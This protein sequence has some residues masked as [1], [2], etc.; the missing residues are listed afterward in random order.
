MTLTRSIRFTLFAL[1]TCLWTTTLWAKGSGNA[2]IKVTMEPEFPLELSLQEVT[3]GVAEFFVVV[4]NQGTLRDFILVKTSH[5][6]FGEAVEEV[7]PKWDFKPVS[8]EGERINAMHRVTVNFRNYGVFVVGLDSVTTIKDSRVRTLAR[9]ARNEKYQVPLLPE[10]DREPKP[11]QVVHPS[12]PNSQSIPEE[13][14]RIVYNFFF[15]QEGRVRIPWINETEFQHVDESILDATYNALM[16]WE[17]TPPT[18][19][20]EKVIAQ[21]SQPFWFTSKKSSLTDIR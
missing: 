7:L 19:N 10:L 1:F 13:G 17:F 18:I 21:V 16:Q 20:G 9:T 3:E 11:L 8:I 5:P 2:A 6:L 15:D 14:L 4:D 12:I